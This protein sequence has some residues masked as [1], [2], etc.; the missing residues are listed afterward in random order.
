MARPSP[1]SLHTRSVKSTNSKSKG[2][3]GSAPDIPSDTSAAIPAVGLHSTAKP[4]KRRA[5]SVAEW[6]KLRAAKLAERKSEVLSAVEPQ[7]TPLPLTRPSISVDRRN[8]LR[9]AGR[10]NG[11]SIELERSHVGYIEEQEGERYETD[12]DASED[13]SR[14]EDKDMDGLTFNQRQILYFRCLTYEEKRQRLIQWGV[15]W[16]SSWWR[17]IYQVDVASQAPSGIQPS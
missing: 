11:R 7:N 6:S 13:E 8:V 5:I 10:A 15:P 1:K 12:S 4:V 3:K 2:T 16:S 14:V 9:P 17:R